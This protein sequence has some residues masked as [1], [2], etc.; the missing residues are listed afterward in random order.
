M[1]PNITYDGDW[2][3]TLGK[4]LY[5][6]MPNATHGRGSMISGAI[7]LSKYTQITVE[8]TSNGETFSKVLDVSGYSQTAYLGIGIYS[9][10]SNDKR[11]RL[12]IN[13]T[14]SPSYLDGPNLIVLLAVLD[15][16][17]LAY[18]QEVCITALYLK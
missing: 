8:G 15:G 16:N 9:P 7:D 18:G 4:G 2:T 1:Y 3:Y 14:Q 17:A 6:N 13:N 12:Y 11:L 10:S 5:A